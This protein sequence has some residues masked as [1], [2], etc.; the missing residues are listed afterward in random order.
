MAFC[1]RAPAFEKKLLPL[2]FPEMQTKELAFYQK[3]EMPR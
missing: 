2:Y 1:F 3:P